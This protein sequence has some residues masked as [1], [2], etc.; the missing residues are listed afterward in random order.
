MADMR[1]I[2]MKFSFYKYTSFREDFFDEP[3]IRATPATE[4][5]DPFE[6]KFTAEQVRQYQEN[7]DIFD[8]EYGINDTI[9]VFQSNFE[10]LGIISLSDNY[11]NNVM[12][13]HYGDNHRGNVI[14]F[15]LSEEISFFTNEIEHKTFGDVYAFPEKVTY[16]KNLPD[17]S[18]IEKLS[19]NDLDRLKEYGEFFYKEFNRRILLC[20]SSDWSYEQES[21]MIVRLQDADRIICQYDQDSWKHIEKQCNR[22]KRIVIEKLNSGKISITYPVGFESINDDVGDESIKFEIFL[23]TKNLNPIHLFRVNPECITAI[24]FGCN[25]KSTEIGNKNPKSLKNAKFYKMVIS[26]NSFSLIPTLKDE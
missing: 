3:M 8:D 22:D 20:K 10:E 25:S 21:R 1:Q 7:R 14:Q 11:N 23:L 9:D 5:N 16:S 6:L 19:S 26:E 18:I 13:S 12:W 4:L 15:T 2:G 24:F 17:F